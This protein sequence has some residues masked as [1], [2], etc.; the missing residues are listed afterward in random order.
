MLDPHTGEVLALANWM[1][2]Y[3]GFN[4]S[5]L[6]DSPPEARLDRA[7]AVPVRAGQHV[8]AVHRRAGPDVGRDDAGARCGR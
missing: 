5:N 3:P 8:Q 7:V 6:G 4:P 1:K 2:D